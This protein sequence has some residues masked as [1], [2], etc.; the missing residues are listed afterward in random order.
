MDGRST[1][2]M[3]CLPEFNDSSTIRWRVEFHGNHSSCFTGLLIL[4]PLFSHFLGWRGFHLTFSCVFAMVLVELLWAWVVSKLSKQKA[5]ASF[6]EAW[7]WARTSS[8]FSF[9]ELLLQAWLCMVL[10]CV[11]L[12]TA[13]CSFASHAYISISVYFKLNIIFQFNTTD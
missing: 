5:G 7:T 12:D 10:L 2:H 1:K 13:Q 3:Y 6:M 11:L 8:F 9:Q 4:H